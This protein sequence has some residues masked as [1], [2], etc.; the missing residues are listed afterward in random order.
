MAFGIVIDFCRWPGTQLFCSGK[1]KAL[2][3]VAWFPRQGTSVRQGLLHGKYV[4]INR[5]FMT[6]TRELKTLKVYMWDL[7]FHIIGHINKALSQ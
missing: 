2:V 5:R 6:R 3:I 4:K 7:T 1:R